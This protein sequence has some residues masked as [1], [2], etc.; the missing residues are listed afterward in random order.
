M[1]DLIASQLR[2]GRLT[3]QI[4]QGRATWPTEK[5][6]GRF[7]E[8]SAPTVS[9]VLKD[10]PSMCLCGKGDSIFVREKQ[11]ARDGAGARINSADERS[12]LP[13][14]TRPLREESTIQN[15]T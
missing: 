3:G 13:I 8:Y 5:S 15:L 4:V 9:S 11:V 2:I 6:G 14:G 12:A 10:G 1:S 7:T